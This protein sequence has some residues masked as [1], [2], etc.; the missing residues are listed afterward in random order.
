LRVFGAMRPLYQPTQKN[1]AA[2]GIEVV[3]L[4][5]NQLLVIPK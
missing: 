1:T 4:C 2:S 3:L 5:C